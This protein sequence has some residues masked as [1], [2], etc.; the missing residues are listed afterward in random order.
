VG[1]F[2]GWSFTREER[3]FPLQIV[4]F[5]FF[6]PLTAIVPRPPVGRLYS[7]C[8]WGILASNIAAGNIL[9]ITH[10]FSL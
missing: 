5:F 6:P 4:L 3:R 9:S 2:I 1:G 7:I 8:P 10:L